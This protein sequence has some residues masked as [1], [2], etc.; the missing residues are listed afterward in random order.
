M[1]AIVLPALLLLSLPSG[2]WAQSLLKDDASPYDPP[3]K[4]ALKKRDHVQI[5]FQERGNGPKAPESRPRWDKELRQWVRF[6]GKEAPAAAVTVT[7]EVIDI[8][9][10]GTLVLQAIKRRSVNG[11]VETLRLTGEATPASVTMNK[12]S[13]EGL[14]NVSV[15][16]EGP[17][18]DGAKPGLLGRIFDKLWPF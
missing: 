7:A 2:A 13:S 15:S 17:A 1:K 10:N 6:E 18:G 5:E 11:D 12:V 3:K 8:R 16:Y 14:A 9:P 4:P